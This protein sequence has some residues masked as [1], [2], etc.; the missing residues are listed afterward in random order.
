MDPQVLQV[1]TSDERVNLFLKIVG[2]N[3]VEIFMKRQF[4]RAILWDNFRILD[5]LNE[6]DIWALQFRK[7]IICEDF[8]LKAK[9]LLIEHEFCAQTSEK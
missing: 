5:S 3:F 2:R 9:R 8:F 6:G 4:S 1:W 7:Y